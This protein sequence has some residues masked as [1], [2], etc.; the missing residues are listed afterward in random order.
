[1]EIL[2]SRLPVHLSSFY[3]EVRQEATLFATLLA[4]A[5][6]LPA[7][8]SAYGSWP[9]GQAAANAKASLL[10]SMLPGP[11]GGGA[12]GGKK[13][14]AGLPEMPGAPSLGELERWEAGSVRFC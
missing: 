11:A 8:S 2:R 14:G 1:M 5:Q 9:L 4:H 13:G 10:C 7:T 3:F 6:V 12:A